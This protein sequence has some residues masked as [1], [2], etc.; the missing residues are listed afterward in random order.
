MTA[1]SG[2][3]VTSSGTGMG[4]GS[5]SSSSSGG[6]PQCA[7]NGDC[8]ADT[9]C[10]TFQCTGGICESKYAAAGVAVGDP[11]PNDCKQQQCDGQGNEVTGPNV[12]DLPADDSNPCTQA[13]CAPDGTPQQAALPAGTACDAGSMVCDGNA[14]CYDRCSDGVKDFDEF[15]IDCGGSACGGCLG[16]P[17]GANDCAKGICCYCNDICLS[18]L[19]CDKN[20]GG[21]GTGGLPP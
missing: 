14:N 4:G 19:I 8:G 16:D 3:V 6:M 5:P 11:T 21:G 13:Q 12:N 20:C 17:C 1:G 18:P 2:G 10:K 9:A 7:V 15:G